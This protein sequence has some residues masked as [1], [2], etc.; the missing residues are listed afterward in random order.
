[1]VVTSSTEEVSIR[2]I[3][4]GEEV[5]MEMVIADLYAKFVENKV[6]WQ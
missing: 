3:E 5:A 4:E 2:I 6:M 1:M